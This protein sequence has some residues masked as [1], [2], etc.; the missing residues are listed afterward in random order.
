MPVNSSICV[1][2]SGQ[3]RSWRQV[4]DTHLQIFK[5]FESVRVFA[6][7]WDVEEAA[8]IQSFCDCLNG[9]SNIDITLI[10]EPMDTRFYNKNVKRIAPVRYMKNSIWMLLGMTSVF[11]RSDVIQSTYDFVIRIRYDI[12]V[13]HNTVKD[14]YP[15][16]LKHNWANEK[17]FFDGYFVLAGSVACRFYENLLE[18]FFGFAWSHQIE[19]PE[20]IISYLLHNAGAGS[21]G[22]NDSRAE[23]IRANGVVDQCFYAYRDKT[24]VQNIKSDVDMVARFNRGGISILKRSALNYY[25][26]GNVLYRTLLLS[27]ALFK[28]SYVYKSI[29]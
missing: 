21:F 25:L 9:V 28:D 23:I 22:R 6:H 4:I 5:K 29:R 10:V 27:I 17:V 14:S 8:E 19:A 11:H 18:Q 3:L 1:L 15:C 12:R 7:F 2:Y 13:T 20:F 24:V 16:L 26:F